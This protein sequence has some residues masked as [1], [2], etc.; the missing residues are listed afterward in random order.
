MHYTRFREVLSKPTENV[1]MR[2]KN[3]SVSPFIQNLA[4]ELSLLGTGN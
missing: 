2:L 4:A 3:L 1:H